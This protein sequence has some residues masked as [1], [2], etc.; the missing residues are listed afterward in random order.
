VCY[1]GVGCFRDAAPFGYLD[2]L[3]SPPEQVLTRFLFYSRRGDAFPLPFAN[4]TDAPASSPAPRRPARDS[5]PSLSAS[6]A[7]PDG[8]PFVAATAFEPS[9]WLAAGL[10][11]SAPTRVIVHGFGSSCG[12]VWV[13]EMRSA[14]M[15]VVSAVVRSP[16]P[17][18]APRR[19]PPF[20]S[21]A[22]HCNVS[23]VSSQKS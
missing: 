14:L 2:M 4:I 16:P 17:P 9:D 5:P 11:A 22:H 1:E 12:N 18:G 21:P 3:P 19:F 8:A 6:L 10:N 7:S 15:S 20:H 23:Y 13:L